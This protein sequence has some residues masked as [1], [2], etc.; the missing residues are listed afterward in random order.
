VINNLEDDIE[1]KSG[2]IKELEIVINCYQKFS[3]RDKT[4]AFSKLKYSVD[5]EYERKRR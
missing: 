4:T 2:Y 5:N 1:R 3:N